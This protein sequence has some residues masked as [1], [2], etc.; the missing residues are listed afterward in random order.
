[1]PK[2]SII[3]NNKDFKIQRLE[4]GAWATNAY[5]VVC[6]QTGKSAAIDVPPGARTIIKHLKGTS[7]QYILLTHNHI[8]HIYG[9]RAM[10]AR[11]SAPLAVHKSDN[12]DWLPFRPDIILKD[13]SVIQVGNIKIRTIHT[14]G[15]TPG[16]VCF[17]IGKYLIAGDTI[18]P[19][20]PGRT[21]TA[22]RFRMIVHCLTSKIFTLP[23]N[24]S[25]HPGHGEPTVLGKEK[26]EFAVFSSRPHDPDLFGDIV[27]LTS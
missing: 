3:A 4:I 12:Q 1:M 21:V 19:G 17:K 13:G 5:V 27:W 25:I 2:I 26:K 9:L 22:G 16:S 6:K 23:D 7:L 10:R 14:P 8:D 18:F 11:V 15:H 20:G 24:T